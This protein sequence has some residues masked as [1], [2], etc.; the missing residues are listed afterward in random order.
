M[1]LRSTV[2]GVVATAL[3]GAAAVAP[4]D[5]AAGD[6]GKILLGAVGGLLAGKMVSD[7]EQKKQAEA[8]QQGAEDQYIAQQQYN[9]QM[10]QASQQAAA[11]SPEARLERLKKLRDQGLISDSDYNTQKAAIVSSL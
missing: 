5:A 7:H 10:A 3:I 6:G 11:N 4:R 2:V 8:Y 9:Q 1:T